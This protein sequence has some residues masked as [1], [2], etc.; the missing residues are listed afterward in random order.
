M[1]VKDFGWAV[2]ATLGAIACGGGGSD[3]AEGADY[4]GGVGPGGAESTDNPELQGGDEGVLQIS[5]GVRS[6]RFAWSQVSGADEYQIEESHDRGETF[7][8]F[9]PRVTE[10]TFEKEVSVHQ[11]DWTQVRYRLVACTDV[12]CK[13]GDPMGAEHAAVDCVGF[14]KPQ[15]PQGKTPGPSMGML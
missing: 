1:K 10:R 11:V 2:L 9:S 13:P 6:L 8:S 15:E 7:S 3:A 14:F 5:C 12:G 4:T